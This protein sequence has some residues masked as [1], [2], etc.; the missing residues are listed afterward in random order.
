MRPLETEHRGWRLRV[1]AHSVGRGWSALVEVWPPGSPGTAEAQVVPFS[2]TLASE[3]LAQSAGRTAAVRW[4]D[5]AQSPS[6][7]SPDAT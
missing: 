5:R 6:P 1:I 7:P 4:I 3:K 2:G